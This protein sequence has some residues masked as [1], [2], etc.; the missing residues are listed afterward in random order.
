MRLA[1][2]WVLLV[3]CA[4]SSFQVASQTTDAAVDTEIADTDATA[5]DSGTPASD[6]NV[7]ESSTGCGALTEAAEVWVDA[8]ST[9]AMPSGAPSCPFR[10]LIEAVS[11]VNS[12]P[13]KARTIRVRA[14]TY[15]E[16]AAI[17]L[18]PQITLLGAGVGKTILAG[19]GPCMGIGS[20]IVRVDGGATL[21]G[22]TVDAS[23]TAKH[24]IVT[25][26]TDP[27]GNP[28][29]KNV[30]VTGAVGDGNAGILSSSGSV[31][32]PNV[33]A[34][35]NRL[36]LVIWGNQKVSI[37]GGNNHFDKNTEIGINHEG[38]GPLVFDNGGS[39]NANGGD[40]VR[41]GS[42]ATPAPPA[43]GIALIEV[44]G[45]AGAG[46]RVM[47][48]AGLTLRGCRIVSN[49]W[50]VIAVLG[51]TNVVD[52][53]TGGSAGNNNFGGSGVRNE[54]AALCVG[55]ARA[56]ALP[57]VTNR[58]FTCPADGKPLNDISTTA[59]CEA[60]VSYSDVYFRGLTP[61]DTS[62][63]SIGG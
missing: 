38:T 14:G 45:N 3:G 41:L 31:L 40:G 35:G 39:V 33:E 6:G 13:P 34:S 4:S 19:G 55:G 59:G 25:G 46:I 18:R 2:G 43:H 11:Y 36:G 1:L 53:G 63:C 20:C 15:T 23:P 16:S 42:M 27:G 28:I 5:I 21:D 56:S 52:L 37:T 48:N 57:A 61:P 60:I 12:L 50:G 17:M 10:H 29:I 7:G 30:K 24:G 22:V 44:I 49:K 58:W 9:F 47:A 26:N 62:G 8:T 32:G 51:S 54:R